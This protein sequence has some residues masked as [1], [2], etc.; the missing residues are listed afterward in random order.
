MRLSSG[1]A[2]ALRRHK[3][4]TPQRGVATID[5]Q[6][7]RPSNI[8]A[9]KC[10]SQ[11]RYLFVGAG[12]LVLTGCATGPLAR[13]TG[14]PYHVVAHKPNDPDKVRVKV[15]LSKQNIYVMEGDRCLMA[16]AC[17]VGMPSK[18]TPK[19]SFTIYNK[20]EHKRSGSYG[21]KVQGDRVVPATSESG[22]P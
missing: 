2:G 10:L 16:V 3:S 4:V 22:I 19:G 11:V 12:L 21:F 7:R 13:V 9:M 14:G 8:E 17:T 5:K 15:S 20:I 6:G 18:P 1:S